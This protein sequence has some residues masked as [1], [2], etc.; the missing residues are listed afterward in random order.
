MPM[1]LQ[2]KNI[3]DSHIPEFKEI[4]SGDTYETVCKDYGYLPTGKRFY[5]D[6]NKKYGHAQIKFESGGEIPD[7]LKGL[8]S[9]RHGE[10]ALLQH[11][12]A[13]WDVHNKAVAA[14]KK[15]QQQKANKTRSATKAK[16]KAKSTAKETVEDGSDKGETTVL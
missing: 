11:L 6:F 8:W 10:T 9:R 13:N 15:E 4:N 14:Q 12:D 5:M 7:S 2:D 1:N 16:S 3:A